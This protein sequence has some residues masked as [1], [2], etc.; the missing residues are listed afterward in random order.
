MEAF[1]NV[2][3]GR[4]LA[5]RDEIDRTLHQAKGVCHALSALLRDLD[6]GDGS[7]AAWAVYSMLE[8]IQQLL[9]AEQAARQGGA[10]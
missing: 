7:H 4:T 1:N 8:R 9:S 5:E 10:S 3:A 2:P 6:D